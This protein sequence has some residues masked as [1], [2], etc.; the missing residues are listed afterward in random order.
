MQETFITH[1]GYLAILLGTFLEGETI[2]VLAGLAAHR[3]YLDLPLVILAAFVGTLLGDQLYF[4]LG[5]RH[6]E[7]LLKRHPA[8][9][10]KIERVDRILSRYQTIMLL[11]FR[12]LYGFRTLSPFVIGMSSIR[13]WKY[14]FL[15]LIGA[16]VWTVFIAYAGYYFGQAVELFLGD[17]KRFEIWVFIAVAL[18]GAAVW[19]H[20]FR[21]RKRGKQG[22]RAVFCIILL[23][24]AILWTGEGRCNLTDLRNA[25]FLLICG[26]VADSHGK[27]IKNAAISLTVRDPKKHAT[28][29]TVTSEDGRYRVETSLPA[30][31]MKSAE[32]L[33]EVRKPSYAPLAAKVAHIVKAKSDER[34]STFYLS[35]SDMTLKRIVSPALWISAAVLLMVYVLIGFEIVHRA[36]AAL[37]GAALLL[38]VSHILGPFF[39]DFDIIRFDAAA[40]AVDLNV[41]LLLFSMMIIVGISEKTGMFQWLAYACYRLAGGRIQ[42]LCA[43]LMI[44]TALIS[45]F[46]DN[47]TTMLLVIPISLQ[48]ARELDINPV[49]LLLP[50][51]FASNVGGSATLIGDPPNIMIGSYAN[52]NFLDFA[53]NLA[54]PC[55]IVLFISIAYFLWYFRK[56]YPRPQSKQTTTPAPSG[57]G[58]CTITDTKLLVLC[59]IFLA[60]T[61]LLFMVHGMFEMAP[62]V[63]AL[64]GATAL[65]VTSRAD[66]VTLLEKKIEWPTLVFFAA[67]FVVVAAAEESGLIHL[68]AEYV[69][70]LSSGSYI[71]ALL[72]VL[73]TSAI[74]SAFIDNIPFT[75]TMLPVVAYLTTTLPIDKAQGLWWALALGACLGGNGTIIGAS[76]NV[77]T[78]GM[79]EKAGH[80]ISFLGY[81]KISFAPMILSI[82][83]CSIWLLLA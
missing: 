14:I 11:S 45:A 31:A 30:G 59:L 74:V 46:L 13:T 32:V 54:I 65:L 51:V 15:N 7:W 35:E 8:W 2:L 55:I 40:R 1:F 82:L 52:L 62:S 61:I 20:H 58:T 42:L 18:A 34:G 70:H 71:F 24:A 50:E 26:Q 29:E 17:I 43:S 25:D 78:V 27:P 38:A 4:Y 36:T 68:I 39:P 48:I 53:R 33:L 79:A 56:D 9:R 69:R 44:V 64:I 66:L 28:K 72:I 80:R 67:L 77:V 19:I 12:F 47:V 10:F 41:I 6:S 57:D 5:R 23:F 83:I 63:A 75:A 60:M 21:R 73:W 49:A 76:A 37:A 22:N 16:A 3:G 81:M